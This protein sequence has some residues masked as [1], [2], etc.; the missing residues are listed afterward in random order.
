MA[1]D[2]RH[3]ARQLETGF[4]VRLLA[5]SGADSD[6]V[7]G[8][9]DLT[10]A[11]D[12]AVDWLDRED[13]KR[14]GTV[15]LAVVRVDDA[16]AEIVLTYPP[17]A[18]DSGQELI[19][20]FGF[21]PTTWRPQHLNRPAGKEPRRTLPDR[22]R[23][24]PAVA[25]AT[26]SAAG[27]SKER[28]DRAR[29]VSARGDAPVEVPARATVGAED[30]RPAAADLPRTYAE[31]EPVEWYEAVRA[32]RD[33][34]KLR[35]QATSMM[36]STWDDPLSRALLVGG[37]FSMW[38][39]VALLEPVFLLLTLTMLSALW[40]RQRRHQDVEPDDDF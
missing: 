23:A 27:S 20:V 35:R 29:P 6:L 14:A 18:P 2:A 5:E 8:L 21:N 33:W 24:A 13:P 11:A 26:A 15:R 38:W 7:S 36:E 37:A 25:A 28:T 31:R 34:A 39:T 40:V 10:A 17:A 12:F 16:G 3:A 19:D 22:L 32:P 9:P 4:A 1:D 30:P